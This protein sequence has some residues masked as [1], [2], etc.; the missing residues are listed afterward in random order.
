MFC[1]IIVT[2]IIILIEHS[3]YVSNHSLAVWTESVYVADG[4]GWS[5]RLSRAAWYTWPAWEWALVN[6]QPTQPPSP[7][8]VHL[9]HWLACSNLKPDFS[10]W[11]GMDEFCLLCLRLSM[12]LLLIASKT[13]KRSQKVRIKR[14]NRKDS[15][16]DVTTLSFQLPWKQR[17]RVLCLPKPELRA[18]GS[19]TL[20]LPLPLCSSQASA[21]R[22]SHYW[23]KQEM[24]LWVWGPPGSPQG[25]AVIRIQFGFHFLALWPWV[26]WSWLSEPWCPRLWK[27]N[28]QNCL[29]GP[30][31][32][33]D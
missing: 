4:S 12:F 3:K 5:D 26:T 29:V 15:E 30:G 18:E 21:Y 24:P 20:P 27:E 31:I 19:V 22:L 10:T 9:L 17:G 1:V 32:E 2:I 11:P 25:M 28:N 14:I 8:T 16:P 23:G 7:L 13:F 33:W 6:N